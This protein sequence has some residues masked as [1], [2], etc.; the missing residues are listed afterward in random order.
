[1]LKSVLL[2]VGCYDRRDHSPY[3]PFTN[4]D[5][6]KFTNIGIT[7]FI[8]TDS[9][10]GY[11]SY[12]TDDGTVKHCVTHEDVDALDIDITELKTEYWHEKFKGMYHERIDR[13]SDV[14][15]YNMFRERSLKCARTVWQVNPDAKVWFT[16]PGIEL[17]GLANKFITPFKEE[18]VDKFKAELSEEEWAKVAGF[19]F[20][21][22]AVVNDFTDFDYE[23][24]EYNSTFKNPIVKAMKACSDYVR[25][26]GKKMLWIP[27][28]RHG[29]WAQAAKRLGY[30]ANRTDFFDYIVVQPTYYF[31]KIL[32][33]NIE[34]VRKC[35]EQQAICDFYGQIFGGEKI[36]KTI[37]GPEM[38]LE[39]DKT[40]KNIHVP[41][42][43]ARYLA[44]VEAYRGFVNKVPMVYYAGG[45]DHIMDPKI[46]DH[47]DKFYNQ[48]I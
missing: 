22:E 23:D 19:Y 2:Y 37:I 43:E 21:T 16:F 45:R 31:N 5:I 47:I 3:P 4:E 41:A 32:H 24:L 38:E 35:V 25:S 6:E 9:G 48:K 36:S 27:Y 26:F 14:V 20:S 8:L 33:A 17:Y 42:N 39:G 29:D 30:I 11:N 15:N 28:Y 44:Y 12:I 40:W 7:E 13:I 10:Q 46:I 34:A 18:L 1:M